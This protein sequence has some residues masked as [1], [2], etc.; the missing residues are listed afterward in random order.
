MATRRTWSRSVLAHLPIS[1]ETK[2]FLSEV[3]LPSIHFLLVYKF[4]GNAPQFRAPEG[5]PELLALT[6]EPPDI[7]IDP[8]RNGQVIDIGYGDVEHFVNSSAS[9]FGASLH[10]FL[11]YADRVAKIERDEEACDELR[12]ELRKELTSIDS[13]AFRD[14][15]CFWPLILDTN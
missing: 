12:A 4:A 13:A 3:G 11:A 1:E 5:R 6:A 15:E 14:E 8:T 2:A 9:L 10:A 7:C